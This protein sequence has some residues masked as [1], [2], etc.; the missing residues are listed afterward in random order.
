MAYEI[1][2]VFQ[3][4]EAYESAVERLYDVL[5]MDVGAPAAPPDRSLADASGRGTAE[6]LAAPDL[7]DEPAELADGYS[8]VVEDRTA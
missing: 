8:F 4:M 3:T 5:G 7:D 2:V 1:R 6:W